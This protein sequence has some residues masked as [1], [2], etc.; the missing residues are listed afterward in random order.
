MA[1]F[2]HPEDERY[3]KYK[4]K[5]AKV[6]LFDFEVSILEDKRVDRKK[7]TGIVMCSTFGDQTD[8]EWQKAYNLPI[9]MAITPEGKQ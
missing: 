9:K 7:G 4:G 3:Q 1:V 8:M 5:K 6:P 2:Y